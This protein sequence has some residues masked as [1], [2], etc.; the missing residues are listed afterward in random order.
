MDLTETLY[1]PEPDTE[2]CDATDWMPRHLDRMLQPGV[3]KA[4]G[5]AT[6]ILYVP[7]PGDVAGTYQHW[8][9]QRNDPTI[10]SIAYS[11]Q[12]YEV[13]EALQA[14]MDVLT[15][16]PVLSEQQ[17]GQTSAA[18]RFFQCH[19]PGGR[20]VGYHL[21]EIG[22]CLRILRHAL[23]MRADTILF[24]RNM[25]HFWP[26]GLARLFG[27]RL[28][29]SLHNTLWPIHRTPSRRERLTSRLNGW[30]FRRADQVL[31]VSQSVVDQIR[32]VAGPSARAE[33]QTP[34]YKED[35]TLAFR[36]RPPQAPLRDILYLGRIEV[37]KG[38]FLLLEAFERVAAD[39][40]HLR[41]RFV[42]SGNALED[43]RTAVAGSAYADRISVPGTCNGDQVFAELAKADLLACPTT[44]QF[45]E[46]LAKTPI[47]AV[48]AGVP[49]LVST[50]VPAGSLLGSAVETIPADNIDAWAGALDRLARDPARLAV[51]SRAAIEQRG[52]FFNRNLSLGARLFAALNAQRRHKHAQ[53]AIR[54]RSHLGQ[55]FPIVGKS[56]R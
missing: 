50:V 1:D 22:Y 35:L 51:M 47:E 48:L 15:L 23:R 49:S 42:G 7:G 9:A 37:P 5:R 41:L 19:G 20:S 34:Q 11:A 38:V 21:S 13:A 3:A 30:L 17:D 10:P 44:G 8:Q 25:V 53:P 31:G 56:G 45:S 55:A 29:V 24:Q 28:V 26:L 52:A 40:P 46:G 16:E 32:A 6:R 14:R 36:M 2:T 27:I 39:H 12:V 4:E 54:K 43:L 33:V 18:T